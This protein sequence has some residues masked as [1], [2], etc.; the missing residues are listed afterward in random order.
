LYDTRA[1]GGNILHAVRDRPA[2]CC[3]NHHPPIAGGSLD[4]RSGPRY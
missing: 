2:N 4:H 3:M 1:R